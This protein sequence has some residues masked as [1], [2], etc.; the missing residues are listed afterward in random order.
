MNILKLATT[1]VALFIAVQ[2]GLLAQ[3]EWSLQKCIDYAHKNNLQLQQ[4]KLTGQIGEINHKQSKANFLPSV[5][6]SASYGYSLGRAL[7]PT[8]YSF[9]N[10]NIA[11]TSLSLNASLNLFSGFQNKNTLKRTAMENELNDLLSEDAE[12]DIS[13]AVCSAYLQVILATEQRKVIQEQAN[14]T[15]EQRQQ[16]Q[17][18]VEA[19][20]LA[21]GDLLDLDAQIASDSANLVTA[22]NAIATAY[23]SLQQLM[24]YYPD[25]AFTVVQPKLSTVSSAELEAMSSQQLYENALGHRPEIKS[26]DLQI[27]IAEKNIDISN[28]AKYPRLSLNGNVST[29]ATSLGTK[30]VG[31]EPFETPVFTTDGEVF[32]I[33]NTIPVTEKASYPSQWSDNYNSYIGLSLAVPIF[34]QNRVQNSAQIA[35]LNV[36]NSRVLE[37]QARNQLR[38]DINTAYLAAVSAAKSYEASQSSIKALKLAFEQA[39]KKLNIGMINS[40]DYNTAKNRLAVAELNE[41]AAKYELLFRMKI[42]DFYTG[43]PLTLD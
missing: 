25:E 34:N 12:Q 30:V 19:G 6:G 39:E 22:D 20:T 11:S 31:S 9:S 4:I 33:Q 42:L 40:Y 1:L 36:A 16:M 29:N 8:T 3:E 7:N 43:Q 41:S 2:S 13:L 15:I 24:E 27:Q 26:A 10:R 38:N 14:L 21:Q 23:Q 18:M 35:E 32:Y 5:N 37:K 28:A 17:K